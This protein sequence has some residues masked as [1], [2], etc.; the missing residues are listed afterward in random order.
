MRNLSRVM[1]MSVAENDRVRMKTRPKKLMFLEGELV[2][3]VGIDLE[4]IHKS[5]R[6]LHLLCF[7]QLFFGF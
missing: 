6:L 5:A 2:P 4:Y 7:T 1:S 3:D